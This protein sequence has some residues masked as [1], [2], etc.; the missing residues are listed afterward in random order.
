[1]APGEALK[2]FKQA[3]VE[4]P[5]NN[6]AMLASSTACYVLISLTPL[7]VL[8]IVLLGYLLGRQIVQSYLLGYARSVGL[9]P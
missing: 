6:A 4:C 7:L 9:G 2:L 8:M 1:M 5:K 3:L